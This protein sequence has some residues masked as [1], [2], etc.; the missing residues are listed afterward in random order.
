MRQEAILVNDL[1][2][3][4]LGLDYIAMHFVA[5][6][7]DDVADFVVVFLASLLVEIK[8]VVFALGL[9]SL[10]LGIILV[11]FIQ[12]FGSQIA[13][14]ESNFDAEAFKFQ[15]RHIDLLLID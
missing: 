2:H 3:V 10:P 15:G 13:S 12:V 4:V 9:H 11:I 8:N 6:V 1:D 7:Q 5:F 14:A